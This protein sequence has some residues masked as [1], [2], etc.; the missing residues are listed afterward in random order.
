[1]PKE[2]RYTAFVDILGFSEIIRE[3]GSE[4]PR[5]EEIV[6]AIN[7]IAPYRENNYFA[8]TGF[9]IQNFSDSVV[10]SIPASKENLRKILAALTNLQENFLRLGLFLRGGMTKGL[11]HHDNTT[12]FGRALL[13]AISL[14]ENIACYPRIVI[15]RP[16]FEDI[17]SY[18]IAEDNKYLFGGEIR[19]A[20]DGPIFLDVLYILGEA[21]KKLLS[22]AELD[23]FE[24]RR[25]KYGREISERLQKNLVSAMHDPRHYEKVRWF[26]KY[27]NDC[28]ALPSLK[29]KDV[30]GP[31]ELS[32][33]TKNK[34]I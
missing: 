32:G 27:W 24:K 25:L 2:Q 20:D 10:L 11:L 15:G 14:E 3:L 4:D 34:W 29:N 31:I 5:E 22:G 26:V 30:I 33:D 19:Q 21:N 7:S 13:D 12:A 9:Q 16:V 17:Q 23:V 18:R 28:V 6:K 8:G 1:M